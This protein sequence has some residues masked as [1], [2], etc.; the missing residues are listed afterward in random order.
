MGYPLPH[1]KFLVDTDSSDVGIGAVLSQLQDGQERVVAYHSRALTQP[2]K[3]YCVT[4]RELLAV[5]DAFR[6]FHPYLYSQHFTVCTEHAALHWL[7]NFYHTEGQTARWLQ[8]LQEYDF[9]VEH[10]AGLKHG[11]VDALS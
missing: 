1:G 9:E 4:R 7:F 10:W 5:V 2:E 11:N 3:H 8:R 6:Q